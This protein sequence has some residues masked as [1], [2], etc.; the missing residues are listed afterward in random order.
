M[1]INFLNFSH[2]FSP[3][4]LLSRTFFQELFFFFSFR[5]LQDQRLSRST[6]ANILY[7]LGQT[8]PISNVIRTTLKIFQALLYSFQ[9]VSTE[10]SFSGK[11]CHT[12]NKQIHGSDE[13]MIVF[14]KIIGFSEHTT[15]T[16]PAI[17][18]TK[19]TIET[20]E[21]RCEICSQLTIKL[22]KRRQQRLNAAI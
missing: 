12:K 16:Q 7:I 4:F 3:V 11:S 18:Y 2:D 17:T 19:L 1:P 14:E 20:L 10:M 9:W 8:L 21:Q 5:N 15:E 6:C 22:P 13:P